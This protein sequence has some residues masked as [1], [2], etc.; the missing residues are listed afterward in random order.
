MISSS[1]VEC[2][3]DVHGPRHRLCARPEGVWNERARVRGHGTLDANTGL[4]DERW[5]RIKEWIPK[6]IWGSDGEGN[7]NVELWRYV[8]QWWFRCHHP[9]K[10]DRVARLAEYWGQEASGALTS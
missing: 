9:L 6:G 7:L 4:I 10:A 3:E 2:R 8:Y 1:Q 5:S